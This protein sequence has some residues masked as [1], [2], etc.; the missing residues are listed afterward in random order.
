MS[1]PTRFQCMMDACL[2]NLDF[3]RVYIDDIVIYSKTVDDHYTSLWERLKLIAAHSLKLKLK[4]N[5]FMIPEIV[6]LGHI[7]DKDGI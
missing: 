3:V 1:A 4:K 7:I 5:F 2:K 6:L